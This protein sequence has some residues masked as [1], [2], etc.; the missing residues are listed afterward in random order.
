MNSKYNEDIPLKKYWET[1]SV[2]DIV[3]KELLPYNMDSFF[4]D[5]IDEI[6]KEYI[7][8][9]NKSKTKLTDK[10]LIFFSKNME[11]RIS[12]YREV[13]HLTEIIQIRLYLRVT[14]EIKKEYY[15]FLKQFIE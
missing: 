7:K 14:K 13:Y 3:V 2:S 15:D 8:D 9:V 12:S 5:R 4:Q 11:I 1:Y 6:T 10:Q